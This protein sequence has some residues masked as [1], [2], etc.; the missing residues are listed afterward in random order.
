LPA[1]RAAAGDPASFF[2]FDGP[3]AELFEHGVYWVATWTDAAAILLVGS[4]SH[5]LGGPAMQPR[6][7]I[8]PSVDTDG[9]AKALLESREKE[10]D[11]CGYAYIWSVVMA[12]SLQ[13][14]PVHGLQRLSG[15]A[16]NRGERYGD[17]EQLGQAGLPR[18]L[19]RL[20]LG[21]PIF[22]QGA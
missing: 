1:A 13:T 16:E 6:H 11:R 2:E 18:E 4:D 17:E 9:A 8:S 12:D 19:S 21:S 5:L 14:T 15:V 7:A 10:P 20:I 3:A 22:V